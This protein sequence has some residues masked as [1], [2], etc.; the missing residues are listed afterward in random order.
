MAELLH[1]L[2]LVTGAAGFIGRH[3]ARALAREGWQVHG[4]GHGGWPAEEWRTWGLSQ[5]VGAHVAPGAL[6]S[7]GGTPGLVVHCAGGASVGL[8][9]Q[10]PGEDFE[11]TVASTAAV[12]DYV[13]RR[14]PDAAVVVPS[15]A[16]VYGSTGNAPAAESRPPRPES[17]YGFHKLMAEQ[18]CAEY[19]RFHGTRT[20]AV[21]LF[22]VYGPG[23]R[24][25]LLWDACGKLSRGERTFFGSGGEARDWVHVEDAARLLVQAASRASAGGFV[26]NG[27]SGEAVTVREIVEQAAAALGVAGPLFSGAPRP[28]DPDRLVADPRVGRDLGWRPRTNWRD[29]VREYCAWFQ[30]GAA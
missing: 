4:I 17:V 7:W 11:R 10:R 13:R 2:A 26:V 22:S 28:G 16:A 14:A 25:Q 27:G 5:W 24:K 9:M 12:L 6:D 15:S 3:L 1:R 18:L 23:L 21:R 20:A 19:G 29:G 8:S 30:R